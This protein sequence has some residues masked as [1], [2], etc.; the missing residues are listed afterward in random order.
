MAKDWM[1]TAVKKPGALNAAAAAAGMSKSEYCSNPPSAKASKRCNLWKTFNKYRPEKK[2]MGGQVQ[3][4]GCP[5][6]MEIGPNN[7]L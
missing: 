1:K 2:K 4:C 6:G 3:G 7:V 5:Y